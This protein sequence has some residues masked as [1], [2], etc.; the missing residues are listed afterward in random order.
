MS[1]S[2]FDIETGPQAREL[3]ERNMPEF[4]APGG[5]KDPVKIEAAI[6]EK[7]LEYFERAALCPTTGRVLAIGIIQEGEFTTIDCDQNEAE[8]LKTFWSMITNQGA[9][10]DNVIGF[11]SHGFDLPFLLRRGWKLGVKAPRTVRKGRYFTER[12][13][14]L[15]EL[16]TCG[17]REQRISLDNLAKFL[18]VGQKTGSGADFAKL[19]ESD[20]TKALEYLRNDLELT[21]RCAEALGVL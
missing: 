7:R 5:Y 11:N 17:N 8:G 4:S 21:Q 2:L 1:V 3:L 6:A 9:F 16:W 14:D 15:M 20:R 18:G 12:S 19:W 13:I 10:D